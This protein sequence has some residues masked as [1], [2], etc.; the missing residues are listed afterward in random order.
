MSRQRP[1]YRIVPMPGQ[2]AREADLRRNF[3]RYQAQAVAAQWA[4]EIEVLELAIAGLSI[5][6]IAHALGTE[7]IGQHRPMSAS[8][9]RRIV[10]G[11]QSGVTATPSRL[12]SLSERP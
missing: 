2:K 10:K 4:T 11:P 3:V 8:T 6:A 7:T 9:I 5:P 1:G 12:Q